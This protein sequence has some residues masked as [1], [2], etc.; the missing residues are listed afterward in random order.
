ML[1]HEAQK[2][3]EVV[4]KRGKAEAELRRVYLKL[5]TN[6]ELYLRAYAN[7]KN[8]YEQYSERNQLHVKNLSS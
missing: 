1:L 6:K 2:F 5:C 8:H 3:L 4:N 7:T